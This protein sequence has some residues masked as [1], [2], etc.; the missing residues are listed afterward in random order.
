VELFQ[1]EAKAGEDAHLKAFAEKT[2]PT[3]QMHLQM[4]ERL[5]NE[6]K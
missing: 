5:A 1:K 4:A 6:T 3:I 2:L